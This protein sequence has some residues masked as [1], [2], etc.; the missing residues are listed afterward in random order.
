MRIKQQ[1]EGRVELF[2]LAS[3]WYGTQ[4]DPH[5]SSQAKLFAVG[6]EFYG[7]KPEREPFADRP[8]FT[9]APNDET[10]AKLSHALDD[11]RRLGDADMRLNH[12]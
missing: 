3:G 6:N 1:G 8:F 9:D 11:L 7:T 5:L 4:P 2:L 10:L 12:P